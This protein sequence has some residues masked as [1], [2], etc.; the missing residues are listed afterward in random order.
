MSMTENRALNKQNA[1]LQEAQ[2]RVSFVEEARLGLERNSRSWLTWGT[3][4]WESALLIVK[5][6]APATE[7]YQRGLGSAKSGRMSKRQIK[8]RS[9]TELWRVAHM[10]MSMSFECQLKGLLVEQGKDLPKGGKGHRLPD[11]AALAGVMLSQQALDLLAEL[12]VMNQLGRYPS[13]SEPYTMTTYMW[14][15]DM[16]GLAEASQAINAAWD[17]CLAAKGK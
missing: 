5:Q 4:L 10:L 14:G 8:L 2:G 11:L 13:H 9:K 12:T 1:L 15:I 17:Q 6:A 16:V 3:S 7:A